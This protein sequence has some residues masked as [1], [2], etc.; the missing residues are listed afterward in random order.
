M[1]NRRQDTDL[2]ATGGYAA[3]GPD[4]DVIVLTND[5]ELL[6]VLQD[7]ASPEHILWHALSANEA[8]ELLVGGRCGILI[9]DLQ[10][11]R[12][13]APALLDKLQS[14]FPELVLLATGRR[15]QESVIGALVTSGHVY[16]F[17]HKPLSPARAA[18]FID[19]A[20]R[21]HIELSNATS[22]TRAAM[23][24]LSQQS[25]PRST[26]LGVLV[27]VIVLAG[28][29]VMREP[30]G[31]MVD[32]LILEQPPAAP[33]GDPAIERNLA[34]ARRAI[35]DDRLTP[36]PRDNALDLYRAVLA[37]QPDNAEARA[38]VQRLIGALE[39]QVADAIEANDTP[40]AARAFSNL[41][42][43]DPDNPNLAELRQQLLALSRAQA[44]SKKK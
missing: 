6:G 4:V 41:Q 29:W 26:L 36:P 39:Q 27:G 3:A 31:R 25:A 9:A 23:K 11:L 16:R 5:Y 24:H 17:L 30:I 13:D 14:Q 21:R 33:Q 38:A 34:A 35:A 18:V 19:H 44:T 42:K 15:D 10:V 7:A 28:L 32:S 8:V 37:L 2:S 40:R 22:P 43:A 1:H 20:A 12:G